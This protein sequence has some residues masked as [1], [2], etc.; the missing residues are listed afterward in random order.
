M[1]QTGAG[2]REIQPVGRERLLQA[3]R[4]PNR[5]DSERSSRRLACSTGRLVSSMASGLG[6]RVLR[7]ALS[8]LRPELRPGWVSSSPAAEKEFACMARP[9]RV[10]SE[11]KSLPGLVTLP[12][13]LPALDEW[14][15][16]YPVEDLSIAKHRRR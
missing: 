6:V 3:D 14:A 7:L 2:S 9:P 1:G 13:C 10:A 8:A 15:A 16:G 4:V 5:A 12:A 11:Y